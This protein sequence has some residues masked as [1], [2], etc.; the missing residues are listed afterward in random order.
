MN[1]DI[2]IFFGKTSIAK[3]LAV[4]CLESGDDVERTF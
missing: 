2:I 4:L 1:N 3:A